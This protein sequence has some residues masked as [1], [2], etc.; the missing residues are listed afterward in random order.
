MDQIN[1]WN[2]STHILSLNKFFF[3]A[4]VYTKKNISTDFEQCCVDLWRP[5]STLIS[6]YYYFL[7]FVWWL[8]EHIN[9]ENWK[10]KSDLHIMFHKSGNLT[11]GQNNVIYRSTFKPQANHSL[12]IEPKSFQKYGWRLISQ[13]K[14]IGNGCE[15]HLY[16]LIHIIFIFIPLRAPWN[17]R[18]D[19]CWRLKVTPAII[20]KLLDRPMLCTRK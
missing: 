7:L 13:Q 20:D 1:F 12:K 10:K 11:K 18:F 2:N 9:L 8:S 5:S 3:L 17:A 6:F 4:L 15:Y 19:T 14:S 16:L